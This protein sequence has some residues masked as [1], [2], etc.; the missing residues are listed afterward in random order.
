[1]SKHSQA[2]LSKKAELEKVEA[3][4]KIAIDL[5]SEDLENS[6]LKYLKVGA[7]ISAT[8]LVSYGI[9]RLITK[10][11]P[12]EKLEKTAEAESSMINKVIDKVTDVMAGLVV[13]NISTYIDKL[14]KNLEKDL[15]R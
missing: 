6:A 11:E 4:L 2:F 15:K 10:E 9:F 1:M 5:E 8:A 7:F 14:N 3:D 12:L 13:Q